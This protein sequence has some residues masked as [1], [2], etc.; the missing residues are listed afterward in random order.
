ML[1]ISASSRRL[2]SSSACASASRTIRSMSSLASE[3]W[4]VIVIDCSL[5]VALSWADT[6]TMPL[7]SMSKVTSIWGIP[8]GAGGRSTSWNLPSVLL[9]IAISRSPWSTWISTEGW[10]SS[11]VVKIS[12]RLVGMVVLRSM[13]LVHDLALG[14]DAE[15]Q[16]R[17]VEQEDVLD[18]ALEHAGLHGGADGDD[19]VGVDALVG[20]LARQALH[21]VLDR[22]HAGGPADEDHVVDVGRLEPGVLD[23]GS[24]G[25]RHASTRSAVSSLNFARV[26]LRSRCLGPSDGGG[27]ERQV[28]L[29]LLHRRTARSWP[30]PPPP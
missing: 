18:L 27:D 1:R 15:R 29:G 7:A 28:D 21:E 13:S 19:L 11:A 17:D 25:P 3:D 4:P 5:P 12:D 8:R 9:Y 24:N 26:S 22:G 30:S 23:G 20:L 2:R 10:L 6:C 16:R 14:L